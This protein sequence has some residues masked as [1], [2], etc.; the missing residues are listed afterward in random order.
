MLLIC[1]CVFF[2]IPKDYRTFLTLLK[3]SNV[4]RQVKT[5]Q[6][7]KAYET[8]NDRPKDIIFN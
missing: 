4:G 6:L 8:I 5:N 2:V 7:L 1:T 3:Y